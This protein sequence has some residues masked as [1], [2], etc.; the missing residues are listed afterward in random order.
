MRA[1]VG[2]TI[3]DP[4]QRSTGTHPF[5]GRPAHGCAGRF[6]AVQSDQGV[7]FAAAVCIKV[8]AVRLGADRC[9]NRL[10]PVSRSSLPSFDHPSH[11]TILLPPNYPPIFRP[12]NYTALM[13]GTPLWIV[14]A[15]VFALFFI[16]AALARCADSAGAAHFAAFVASHPDLRLELDDGDGGLEDALAA[17]AKVARSSRRAVNSAAQASVGASELRR[18]RRMCCGWLGVAAM[19]W[20]CGRGLRGCCGGAESA[21]SPH[22]T[23]KRRQYCCLPSDS[24]PVLNLPFLPD[25]YA[26]ALYARYRTLIAINDKSPSRR[27]SDL[28]AN[29]VAPAGY[30]AVANRGLTRIGGPP[31]SIAAIAAAEADLV[32]GAAARSCFLRLWRL[33]WAI[34]HLAAV[35]LVTQHPLLSS[36]VLY[37]PVLP[38]TARLAVTLVTA[39]TALFFSALLYAGEEC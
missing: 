25:A 28:R 19:N 14:L 16:L 8:R 27:A 3:N 15:G 17:L 20:P 7:V 1:S 33:R 2:P 36:F 37:S 23:S 12:Q 22:T 38:R 11:L 24:P 21:A 5:L 34:L 35:Q 30:P 39:I 6:R 26:S 31:V 18:S 4:P 32:E 9:P 29:P 13:N 10:A